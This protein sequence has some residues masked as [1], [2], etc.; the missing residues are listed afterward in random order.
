MLKHLYIQNFTLID[1]LDID[2]Q[3]GFSVITGETGAG[4]SIILGAIGMLLGNRADSKSVKL[5]LDKQDDKPVK[6]TI[7]AHFDLSRYDLESFFQ[8]NDIDYDATDTIIRRELLSTGKS[9][10]FI[11]D[12]PV[13]LQTMK[14]LGEQ[15]IDVHSQHQNL[16]LQKDNFQ[17]NVVDII[18]NDKGALDDYVESYHSLVNKQNELERLRQQIEKDT[19]NR[20]FLEFQ[21]NELS[22]AQLV[23]GMQEQLEQ[24]SETLSHAEDIK[25]ALYQSNQWLSDDEKGIVPQLKRASDALQQIADVYPQVKELTE[26]LNSAYVEIDD[27]ASEVSGDVDNIDFDPTT[28]DAINSKLDLIYALEQKFHV[29]SIS[30]LLQLQE[31]LQEQLAH[32]E[33]SDEALNEIQQEV[34]QLQD[35]CTKKAHLLTELREKAAVIVEKEM[36]D[37]LVPLGIPNVQFRVDITPKDLAIDGADKVQFLFS[38]N[39]STQLQPVSQV[40]SGGEIAR[41]MLSLKAMISGAIKLPTIIF[42]EIDTG[43][44]GK[45]AEKMAYIMQTMGNN[46]RQ[47]ISITHLPQI[48]AM[49]RQHYKVEKIETEQGT[50]SHMSLLS[51]K[52]RVE[53]IA[54]MLS[55]ENI[56]EAAL[57]N[58]RELLGL[59]VN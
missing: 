53:E 15:L 32:I 55:G 34:N 19:E 12:E 18:A 52:E 51:D 38:A 8:S 1:R 11:N 4:K 33:N 24:E 48:A 7:E 23:E 30:E 13:S 42:D 40:A 49:G 16:L 25:T 17:L 43:V 31:Q 46:G 59:P 9:R 39:R 26:R 58:A 28:L 10:A 45:I 5:P 22:Q 50:Q 44:S 56:T 35:I 2:F 54:K 14:R 6:C 36:K 20:A 21:Y 27:I 37:Y 29:N 47:V 57:N 3:S 41:V